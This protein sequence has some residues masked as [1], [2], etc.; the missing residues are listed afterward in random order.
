MGRGEGSGWLTDGDAPL[1]IDGFL[2]DPT[3]AHNDIIGRKLL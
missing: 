2:L 1:H 3:N